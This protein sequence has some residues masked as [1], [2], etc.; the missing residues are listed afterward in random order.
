M[1]N[2][3]NAL[4]AVATEQGEM[5]PGAAVGIVIGVLGEPHSCPS[6]LNIN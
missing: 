2:P 6:P 4:G 1:S 5:N 3:D